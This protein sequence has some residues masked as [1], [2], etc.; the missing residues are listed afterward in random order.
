VYDLHRLPNGGASGDHVIDDG[1]PSLQR[2]S[3]DTAALAVVFGLLAIKSV[4]DVYPVLIGIQLQEF[5][6][7][8]PTLE[9]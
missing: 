1:D 2:M 8:L 5:S 4:G 9:Q 7:G 6:L 3:D